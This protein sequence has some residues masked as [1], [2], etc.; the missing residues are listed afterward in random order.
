[1]NAAARQFDTVVLDPP[2]LALSRAGLEDAL[3]K[4]YDLNTL[5]LQAVKPGGFFVTCSCSGLVS[6]EQFTEMVMRAARRARR[7]VQ[8]LDFTGAG[9]DHPVMPSCP[10]S[11]YLKAIWLRVL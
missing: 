4:Y 9:A 1:M 2:K 8:I 11:A 7:P 6:N 3:R 10:Q 5:A